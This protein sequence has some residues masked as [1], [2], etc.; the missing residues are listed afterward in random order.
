MY[1]LPS[2]LVESDFEDYIFSQQ[3][4]IF[5]ANPNIPTKICLK[6]FIVSFT[7]IFGVT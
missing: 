4:G 7:A 5:F 2:S 3:L 1:D 6:Y